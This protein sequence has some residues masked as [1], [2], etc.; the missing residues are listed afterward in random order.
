[1]IQTPIYWESR[2]REFFGISIV[3]SVLSSFSSARVLFV[4][5]Y[6]LE[7]NLLFRVFA[8]I[9]KLFSCVDWC[10]WKVLYEF[11]NLCIVAVVF[12]VLYQTEIRTAAAAES[13]TEV[14]D[15]QC[16]N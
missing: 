4:F 9:C 3:V 10:I 1:M 15:T 12:S 16:G 2:T 11:T 14:S 7:C 13:R 8:L 5:A 6:R